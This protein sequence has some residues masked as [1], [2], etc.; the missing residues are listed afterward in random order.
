[1]NV[2]QSKKAF[3]GVRK[4]LERARVDV[5]P[6]M[7]PLLSTWESGDMIEELAK[8]DKG[9]ISPSLGVNAFHVVRS[10]SSIGHCVVVRPVS[11]S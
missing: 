5:T 7:E 1:M 11:A 4:Y 3:Q 9:S 8:K 2:L 6:Q 10:L